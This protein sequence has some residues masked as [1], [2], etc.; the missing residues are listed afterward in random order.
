MVFVLRIF[1]KEYWL[2]NMV[3]K[4]IKVNLTGKQIYDKS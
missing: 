4:L 3:Q 1:D 2:S